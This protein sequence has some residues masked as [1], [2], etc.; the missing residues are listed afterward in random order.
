M[1][2]FEFEVKVKW[3]MELDLLDDGSRIAEKDTRWEMGDA[4]GSLWG[5]ER[6]I[7]G[8]TCYAR[9]C[10]LRFV[11]GLSYNQSAVSLFLSLFLCLLIFLPAL[12]I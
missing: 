4:E 5:E 11:R 1:D 2:F 8:D 7:M 12:I 6:K 10:A 3:D 9:V